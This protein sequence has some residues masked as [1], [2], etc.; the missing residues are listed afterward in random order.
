ML[1]CHPESSPNHAC[2][3]TKSGHARCKNSN[4]KP[5]I[6]KLYARRGFR[7]ATISSRL[8][9]QRTTSRVSLK[10]PLLLCEARLLAKATVDRLLSPTLARH[11][12]PSFHCGPQ[13]FFP[14]RPH[15]SRQLIRMITAPGR[16]PH[17]PRWRRARTM[18]VR[19]RGMGVAMPERWI[20]ASLR[21]ITSSRRMAAG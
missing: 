17:S 9:P 5:Y 2:R 10:N 19:P 13:P 6:W 18:A 15:H 21:L 7:R 11:V 12:G 16:P 20:R 14:L 1:G 8:H 3:Q 4:K